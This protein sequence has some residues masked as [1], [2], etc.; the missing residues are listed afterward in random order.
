M[1]ACVNCVGSAVVHFT[2]ESSSATATAFAAKGR[3]N[4]CTAAGNPRRANVFAR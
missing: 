3:A 2:N 4:A 1:P